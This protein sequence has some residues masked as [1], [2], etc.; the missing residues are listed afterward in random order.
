MPKDDLDMQ[1]KIATDYNDAGVKQAKDDLQ[2]LSQAAAEPVQGSGNAAAEETRRS[3]ALAAMMQLEAKTRRE[4]QAEIKRLSAARKEAAAAGD[5]ERFASLSEQLGRTKKAYNELQNAANIN[6]AT[7]IGQASAGMQFAGTLSSLGA[8]LKSGQ[9]DL[10]GMVNGVMSLGMALKAG[11]GPIGW[12]MAGVEALSSVIQLFIDR[13]KGAAIAADELAAAQNRAAEAAIQAGKAIANAKDAHARMA[14]EKQEKENKR[15]LNQEKQKTASLLSEQ[16]SRITGELNLLNEQQA[17][18]EALMQARITMGEAT[19]QDLLNL[20]ENYTKKSDALNAKMSSAEANATVDKTAAN[21]KES[22]QKVDALQKRL[23]G[24]QKLAGDDVWQKFDDPKLETIEA[25]IDALK[26]NVTYEENA[27]KDV[28][29]QAEEWHANQNLFSGA[30]KKWVSNM[31]LADN[32]IDEWNKS[33]S[34]QKGRLQSAT[35]QLRLKLE[36]LAT[37]LGLG[38]DDDSI[39]RL[40]ELLELRQQKKDIE[41]TLTEEKDN[42]LQLQEENKLAEEGKK[43]TAEINDAKKNRR[44]AELK[45][46]MAEDE[47]KKI[48]EQWRQKQKETHDNQLKFAREQLQG[49]KEGSEAWKKWTERTNQAEAGVRQDEWAE[50]QKLSLDAQQE[51]LRRTID[52]LPEQSAE[53]QNWTRQLDSNEAAQRMEGWRKA[54]YRTLDEQQLYVERMLQATREGTLEWE[55]WKEE[56]TKLDNRQVLEEMEKRKKQFKISRSYAD[57]SSRTEA[58]K[59]KE[60]GEILRAQQDYLRALLQRPDLSADTQKKINEEL[61]GVSRELEGYKTTVNEAAR[62]AVNDLKAPKLPNMEAENKSFTGNLK[63]A[64]QAYVAA[65]QRATRAA[66]RG[67][68]KGLAAAQARMARHIQ[69]MEANTG[70]SGKYL[71]AFNR[72]AEKLAAIMQS[73]VRGATVGQALRKR[74]NASLQEALDSTKKATQN[75]PPITTEG[76]KTQPP[77]PPPTPRPDPIPTPKPEREPDSSKNDESSAALQ[78]AEA[79]LEE[80]E[81]SIETLNANFER[82]ASIIERMPE[83][84]DSLSRHFQ[85]KLSTLENSLSRMNH[86]I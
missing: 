65:V 66:L 57:A 64:Q 38:T 20:R 77:L 4:L 35:G 22:T 80:S 3:Q 78:R 27:L 46:R 28:K 81:R 67:D 54:Q 71:D 45:A 43:A 2:A 60:D 50:V 69:S 74:I 41:K 30:A 68:E 25:E 59:L 15:E 33:L 32:E 16:K 70:Y 51:W 26:A 18:E 36:R 84:I 11:L 7:L 73:D 79:A 85:N 61:R 1:I 19:E 52:S 9:A 5:S 63:A 53:R 12:V 62:Q 10:A 40:G 58:Q 86:N 72:D 29:A 37:Q 49:M 55:R 82:L 23:E 21:L 47:S 56:A 42:L 31:G 76:A 39:R 48:E 75:P 13:Q 6:K 34:E 24:L 44:D 8:Q 17:A 83:L 14:F